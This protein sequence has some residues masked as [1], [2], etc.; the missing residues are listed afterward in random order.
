MFCIFF[1]FPYNVFIFCVVF[2]F[3]FLAKQTVNNLSCFLCGDRFLR[4]WGVVQGFSGVGPDVLY[5][6]L[7]GNRDFSDIGTRACSQVKIRD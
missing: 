2:T 3:F 1:N 6:D 4:T 5:W 7:F